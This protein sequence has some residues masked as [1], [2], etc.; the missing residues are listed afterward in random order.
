MKIREEAKY[1]TGLFYQK[2]SMTTLLWRVGPCFRP[3]WLHQ[4]PS[5][6]HVPSAPLCRN[7]GWG[8]P[9]SAMLHTPC[10]STWFSQHLKQLTH[11]HIKNN[12][13]EL[14]QVTRPSTSFQVPFIHIFEF[15]YWLSSF[16]IPPIDTE[17]SKSY[18]KCKQ[19]THRTQ[20]TPDTNGAYGLCWTYCWTLTFRSNMT[21][22]WYSSFRAS[23]WK[24]FCCLG[25]WFDDWLYLEWWATALPWDQTISQLCKRKWHHM[26]IHT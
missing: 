4:I 6:C 11:V 19:E 14:A 3:G 16:Q 20:S 25:H 17:T 5:S 21:L 13:L 2:V 8:F 22:P 24:S 12:H 26:L 9:C 10:G 18:P 7:P 23:D 1:L 15:F